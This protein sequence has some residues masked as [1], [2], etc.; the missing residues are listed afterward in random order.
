MTSRLNPQLNS[1]R[2]LD[3]TISVFSRV[4]FI[5][6]WTVDILHSWGNNVDAI[7]HLP[8]YF[9]RSSSLFSIS[10]TN[11]MYV[12]LIGNPSSIDVS[13]YFFNSA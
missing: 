1:I 8:S 2:D 10:K 11:V 13:L 6:K 5:L 9:F 3:G 7:N 12:P 4:L